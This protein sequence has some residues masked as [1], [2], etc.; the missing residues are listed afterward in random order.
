MKRSMREKTI[1]SSWA[2]RPTLASGASPASKASVS[3]VGVVVR[4]SST[5]ARIAMTTR[6]E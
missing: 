3:S 2:G 5:P 1:A 6:S 4:S